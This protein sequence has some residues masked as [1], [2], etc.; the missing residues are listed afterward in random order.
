[1]M[2]VLP[3]NEAELYVEQLRIFELRDVGSPGY[4]NG[5]EYLP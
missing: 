5:A 4:G 3:A 2:D 1:M